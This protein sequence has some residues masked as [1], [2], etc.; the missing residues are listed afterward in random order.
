MIDAKKLKYRY[1]RSAKHGSLT[2]AT[3]INDEI[4]DKVTSIYIGVAFCSPKEKNFSKEKGRLISLGRIMSLHYKDF[5]SVKK[6]KF[7]K[8]ES[9]ER[10]MCSAMCFKLLKGVDVI[11]ANTIDSYVKEALH[12]VIKGPK[13]YNK[14]IKVWFE[15]NG[16]VDK[17]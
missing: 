13:W 17:P 7:N 9:D 2:V 5:Y 11:N 8:G 15:C 4:E 1:F 14:F 6:I 16:K 12:E 3:Y 10:T